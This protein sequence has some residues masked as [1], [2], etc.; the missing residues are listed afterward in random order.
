MI[1]RENE[2]S[3]SIG[4]KKYLLTGHADLADTNDGNF[5]TRM[6]KGCLNL[7]LQ[8]INGR[9]HFSVIEFKKII[10]Y[11]K[12]IVMMTWQQRCS[13]PVRDSEI[14]HAHARRSSRIV[15]PECQTKVIRTT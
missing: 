1:Q 6:V 2:E 10:C 15:R 3:Y 12:L 5:A 14:A 4:K 8:F 7:S 11:S 9:S 13:N